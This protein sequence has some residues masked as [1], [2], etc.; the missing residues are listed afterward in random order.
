MRPGL[1]ARVTGRRSVGERIVLRGRLLPA[2]AGRLALDYLDRSR[3]VRVGAAGHF[4]V[5]LPSEVP[6]RTRWR[7]RLTPADG[8][9][10][11]SRR[12][13]LVLRAPSLRLGSGGQ[14]VRALEQRLRNLHFVIRGVDT[15]YGWDTVEAVLAFQKVH[16]LARTGRVSAGV[17]SRLGR[18]R[19]PRAFVPSGTHL[20]ISK[21][22]QVM[23]EVVDG[24]VARAVH[25]STGA[26]GNTPVGRWRVYRLGP[27]Y[28]ALGMYYSLYFLRGFAIHGY[29]SVP[30]FPASHGCVRTP[31]WFARGFYDRWAR[32]GTQVLVFP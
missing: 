8:F 14:A 4:R 29:R 26:T 31:I 23:F 30:A 19:I 24:R 15:R 2:D 7:L 25:V 16:G 28:N 12:H 20:E 22:K 9:E 10:R 6:G 13:A 32:L 17:W 27:G 3:R 5:V 11:V 21:T 1:T 18:A